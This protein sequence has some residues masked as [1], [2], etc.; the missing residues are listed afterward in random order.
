MTLDMKRRFP[1]IPSILV[2]ALVA[3]AGLSKG[4]AADAA[5]AST[6]PSKTV[7]YG[8]LNLDSTAGAN[9]LY[10]RLRRAAEEVCSPFDSRELSQRRVWQTCV[11]RALTTAVVQVNKPK[12]TAL[13]NQTRSG[14]NGNS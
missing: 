10:A 11:D 4:G 8:D 7:T 14:G 9:A 2:T 3:F 5:D 12:V 1:A 13:H 6:P